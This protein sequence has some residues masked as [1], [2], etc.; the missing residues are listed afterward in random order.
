MATSE[1]DHLDPKPLVDVDIVSRLKRL[2]T[3]KRPGF[4]N[5][6]FNT[7]TR[8]ASEYL[9]ALRSSIKQADAEACRSAAHAFKGGSL[10]IGASRLSSMLAQIEM[11]AKNGELDAID[12]EALRS[13][14]DQSCIALRDALGLVD[15]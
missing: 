15:S 2:E 7:Y 10:N 8:S 4:L 14:H 11:S 3:P 5:K 9:E 6:L 13:M 12:L 1:A